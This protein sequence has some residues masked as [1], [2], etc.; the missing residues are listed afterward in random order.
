MAVAV[1]VCVVVCAVVVGVV[2]VVVGVVTVGVMR[3]TVVAVTVTVIV[4]RVPVVAMTV[5]VVRVPVI[6]IVAAPSRP[7]RRI[8]LLHPADRQLRLRV[9]GRMIVAVIV[10]AATSLRRCVAS[11][12]RV[13]NAVRFGHDVL[14]IA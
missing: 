11:A 13:V 12:V 14:L 7:G 3:V 9:V 8:V 2:T 4:V 6:V 5:F 10:R 1:T